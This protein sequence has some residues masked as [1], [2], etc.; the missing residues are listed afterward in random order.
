[1]EREWLFD[2]CQEVQARP[3]GCLDLWAREHYKSTIITFGKTLQDILASHGDDPLTD[4]AGREPTFGIFSHTRPIAKG[5]L[6]QIKI[7]CESNELLKTLFPDVLYENPHRDAPKWSEDDGIV[8]KRKSNPKESTLEAWGLV[9]GQ[10]TS[11]HFFVRVYDDTVTR[12][13]VSSPDAIRKTTRALEDSFNLGSE[14]GYER[15]V[16]T[17]WHFSDTYK[18]LLD[19]GYLYARIHPGTVD[20]TPEGDPV[21]W[22][23]ETLA[24]KRRKQGPY[25]FG[26]QILLN[27]KSESVMGFKPE[28]LR[29][30]KEDPS[31]GTNRYLL[32]D[33]ANEKK[34]ES[35]YTSMWV[36]GLGTDGNYYALDM[37]RDRLSLTERGDAVFKLHRKWKPLGVGY[38]KYGMQADVEY[39]TDR[40]ERENYRFEIT[41]LGGQ[42]SKPDRI[43]RLVPIFEQGRMWLPEHCHRTDYQGESQDLVSV[44]ESQEYDAFPLGDHEDM[45]DAL[46]RITEEDMHLDWPLVQ[47]SKLRYRPLNNLSSGARAN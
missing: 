24:D 8:F 12:E 39:L 11:K 5:F 35:D 41:P 47:E 15:F 20:G 25:V 13:S 7:E 44:F 2:R 17:R 19:R 40:M 29:H 9:D 21:L 10:P 45:L 36:I 31:K 26:C 28:W 18:Q 23:R 16:G 30:Y 38:E 22:S 14:G 34:K 43:R 32:V 42:L 1:M 3:N 37:I 6:R 33:P 27:P 4:W 46:A